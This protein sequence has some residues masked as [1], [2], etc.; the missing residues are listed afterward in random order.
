MKL[1][2]LMFVKWLCA[3]VAV[4]LLLCFDLFKSQATSK[5][6]L[7]AIEMVSSQ[8]RFYYQTEKDSEKACL[9]DLCRTAKP[10]SQLEPLLDLKRFN[11]I[12]DK[13]CFEQ[14]HLTLSS[15]K[16]VRLFGTPIHVAANNL[17]V[18]QY[19]KGLA[20]YNA[21][22]PLVFVVHLKTGQIRSVKYD[23]HFRNAEQ[24]CFDIDDFLLDIANFGERF[25]DQNIYFLR[26]DKCG[27]YNHIV[28]WR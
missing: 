25:D 9:S 21:I 7:P 19:D 20:D 2:N 14:C 18:V 12:I 22:F 17:L 5:I 26:Q 8:G 4:M 3:G 10:M 11:A 1:R 16:V 13:E 15:G 27:L 28:P 23:F 6:M 24:M